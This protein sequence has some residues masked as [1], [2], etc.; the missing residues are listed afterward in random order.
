MLPCRP[1]LSGASISAGSFAVDISATATAD[2]HLQCQID[3]NS[4]AVEVSCGGRVG[5]TAAA[6]AAPATS[7]LAPQGATSEGRVSAASRL[8]HG[9]LTTGQKAMSATAA[10]HQLSWQDAAFAVSV[11]LHAAAA[12]Q[13]A[14]QQQC[15]LSSG[16]AP[17][18][19]AC[20]LLLPASAAAAAGQTL[21]LA[22]SVQRIGGSRMQT[23]TELVCSS[24]SGALLQ[25]AG[26]VQVLRAAPPSAT[27]WLTAGAAPALQSIWLPWRPQVPADAAPQRAKWALLSYRRPC[28]LAAVCRA[29]ADDAAKLSCVN[30][31]F[32]PEG[33][34]DSDGAQD[35]AAQQDAVATSTQ[36]AATESELAAQLKALRPNHIFCVQ[37]S[38]R[39]SLPGDYWQLQCMHGAFQG[40]SPEQFC[41][42]EIHVNVM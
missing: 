27:G 9:A 24:S 29:S 17:A 22:A 42:P 38:G 23:T 26:L 40:V 25:A 5:L 11:A 32:S 30:I 31:V 28:P 18:L 39:A 4:G 7:L 33:G 41:D 6:T 12:L 10:S 16:R 3:R 2:A 21:H 8:L 35:D 15:S 1:A 34:N 37:Q 13:Q 20:A 19:E 14:G 36:F